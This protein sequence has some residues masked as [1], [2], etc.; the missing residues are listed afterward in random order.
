M[1]C[2][3]C[4]AA[5]ITTGHWRYYELSCAYCAARLIQRIGRLDVM[6]AEI[7]QRRKAVLED[8]CKYGHSES[9]IRELVRGPMAVEPITKPAKG[10]R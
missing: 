6:P 7:K 10:S 1:A 4:E 9:Q 8:W 2:E 5:R 3:C